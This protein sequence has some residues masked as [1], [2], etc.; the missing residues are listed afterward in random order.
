MLLEK[1]EVR[2][3]FVKGMGKS[4]FRI[5]PLTIIP[6]TDLRP[7]PFSFFVLVGAGRAGPSRLGVKSAPSIGEG[8]FC[9]RH[10]AG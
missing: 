2:G 6:L 10:M 5:I 1:N 4:V 3:M 8:K 9:L 7:F